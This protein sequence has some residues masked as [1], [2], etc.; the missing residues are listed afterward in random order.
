[1]P[2]EPQNPYGEQPQ[3][4][5]DPF[6]KP[7][8]ETQPP[9][10]TPHDPP[11][12]PQYGGPASPQYGGPASPHYGGPASPQYGAPGDPQYGA[13]PA[14]QYGAPVGPQYGQP[15]APQ[16]GQ[17]QYQAGPYAGGGYGLPFPRNSLAV[18]SLVLGLCSFVLSC[19][20]FTGIPAVI[21]GNKAKQA[22]ARGEANNP[23][24]ATAGIVLGWIAIALSILGAV[25][26]IAL[27]ANADFRT[28]FSDSVNY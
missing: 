2:S 21:V 16:Y 19:G 15:G 14:P 1:M 26:A 5:V 10:A 27:L 17:P 11:A 6:R 20:L 25:V 13:P 7:D 3:N 24:M 9:A 22:A 4:P 12:A 18:W 23:G 28:E 8:D